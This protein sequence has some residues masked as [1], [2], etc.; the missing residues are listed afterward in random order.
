MRS[1]L[2]TIPGRYYSYP[3]EQHKSLVMDHGKSPAIV[4]TK[5]RSSE[6]ISGDR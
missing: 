6:I 5:P 1:K 4:C 3:G 2:L